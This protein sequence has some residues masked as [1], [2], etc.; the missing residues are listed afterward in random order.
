MW[1]DAGGACESHTA[2]GSHT[3]KAQKVE[4]SKKREFEGYF[5][6][7]RNQKSGSEGIGDTSVAC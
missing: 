6:S 7:R 1:K 2:Q 5:C 3:G 4:M